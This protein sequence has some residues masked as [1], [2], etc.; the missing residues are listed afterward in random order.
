VTYI[1]VKGAIVT[2]SERLKNFPISFFA[3]ILGM[4]GFTLACQRAEKIF[5]VSFEASGYLLWATE[6]LFAAVSVLYLLKVLLHTDKFRDELRHPVRIHF[7]PLIA[8]ICLVNAIIF[9]TLNPTAAWYFWL[10][11]TF[12]QLFFS[13]WIMSSW[14]NHTRYEVHHLNP[15][16]F[17]PIVGFVMVPIAGVELVDLEISWFFFSIGVIFWIV[18]FSL[19]F[20]RVIFHNPIPDKLIP[21]FFILFAPPAIAFIS[22]VKLTGGIDPFARILYYF[23]LFMFILVLFQFGKFAR[24]KF[25]LSWWA[26]SFPLAALTLATLFMYHQNGQLFFALLGVV[27]LALLSGVMLFL[28]VRTWR[29]I[30]NGMIC[31][32]EE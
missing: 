14:I 21:T 6:A 16:W 25:Y 19:I 3:V 4:S 28:A 30:A 32:E 11:G 7:F 31:V 23:S 27:L 29:A 8:K 17:L 18:L 9:L 26:Y 12:L 20:N 24:L 15:A 22:Y 5:K 2:F 13:I 1:S 10:A